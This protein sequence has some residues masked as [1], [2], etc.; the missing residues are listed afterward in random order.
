[1][2]WAGGHLWG[3]LS[4]E[5][6]EMDDFCFKARAAMEESADQGWCGAAPD[7]DGQVSEE[8][9]LRAAAASEGLVLEEGGPDFEEVG[10]SDFYFEAAAAKEKVAEQGFVGA[11]AASEGLVLE[12]GFEEFGLKWADYSDEGDE[13]FEGSTWEA[14]PLLGTALLEAPR[15]RARRRA[16]R[17]KA[18]RG[19]ST[20]DE[21]AASSGWAGRAMVAR[22]AASPDSQADRGRQQRARRAA[23]GEDDEGFDMVGGGWCPG[24]RLR[25]QWQQEMEKLAGS[26]FQ[27]GRCRELKHWLKIWPMA[28]VEEAV[29]AARHRTS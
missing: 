8:A 1:M 3:E 25:A 6:R 11:A 23:R 28:L 16:R 17:R 26:G 20:A 7:S 13:G 14:R 27:Q 21:A 12:D 5:G 29:A 18:G 19:P 24:L 2:R 9:G 4:L 15:G 22:G 10:P